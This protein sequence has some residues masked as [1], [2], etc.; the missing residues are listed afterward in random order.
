MMVMVIV[1]VTMMIMVILMGGECQG[2]VI[3]LRRVRLHC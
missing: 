2:G 3:V 1:I